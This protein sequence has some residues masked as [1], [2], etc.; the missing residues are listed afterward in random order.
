MHAEGGAAGPGVAPPVRFSGPRSPGLGWALFI[1][2]WRQHRSWLAVGV[3][4]GVRFVE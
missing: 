2:K 3:H 1:F 4:R